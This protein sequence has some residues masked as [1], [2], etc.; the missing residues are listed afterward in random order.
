MRAR[1]IAGEAV[2]S[3]E[4]TLAM[5]TNDTLAI[6]SIASHTI[7][8]HTI[9]SIASHTIASEATITPKATFS[10][11][12]VAFAIGLHPSNWTEWSPA[13]KRSIWPNATRHTKSWVAINIIKDVHGVSKLDSIGSKAELL[14]AEPRV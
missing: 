3:P 7:G 12:S 6:T 4:A 10:I 9:A 8:S 13:T 1:T 5:I 14:L 11:A 2:R